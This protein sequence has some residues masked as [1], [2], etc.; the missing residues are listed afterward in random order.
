MP[1][2]EVFAVEKSRHGR[3]IA[4]DVGTDARDDE[5]YAPPQLQVVQ[6][7]S[8]SSFRRRVVDALRSVVPRPGAFSA[9]GRRRSRLRRRDARRR[10]R[11][12]RSI[13]EPTASARGGVR[14]RRRRRRARRRA[15][16]T[17]PTSSTRTSERT[18]SRT[19]RPRRGDGLDARA[20]RLPPRGRRALRPRAGSSGARTRPRSPPDDVAR[21]RGARPVH[22]GGRA[23][24]DRLRRAHARSGGAP[25]ARQVRGTLYVVDRD[26]KR[27]SG[28]PTASA[29][30]TG[31]RTSCPS[32]TR[33]STP[34]SVARVAR[35]RTRRCRRRRACPN[36]AVIGRREDRRRPGLRRRA[37]RVVRVEP[38]GEGERRRSKG[39]RGASA[40]SRA[41]S[42]RATAASTSRPSAGLSENTVRTYVR[43][44]YRSSA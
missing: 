41:C 38:L 7:G 6:H 27:S 37:L 19:S 26:A 40:R 32:R 1:P 17:S 23:R 5:A 3:S 42:S 18:A 36:G 13:R 24:A 9:S 44:L 28:R 2:S 10:R 39:S 8:R 33:W 11:P 31:R 20:P 16:P 30:S 4:S 34:P 43:R 14:L 35:A 15:A 12:R 29:A 22:R 25:R 21:A